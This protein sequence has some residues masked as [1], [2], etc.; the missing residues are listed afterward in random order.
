MQAKNVQVGSTY[1]AYNGDKLAR[2]SVSAVVT[3]RTGKN[4]SESGV[5]GRFIVGEPPYPIVV[6]KLSQLLGNY[7]EHVAL[8][9]ERERELAARHAA[10]FAKTERADELRGILYALIQ[11]PVPV[12]PDNRRQ[13]VFREY[14]MGLEMN[15]LAIE[16]LLPVLREVLTRGSNTNEGEDK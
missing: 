5:E 8:V 14:G 12:G 2:F 10:D 6:L 3:R 13:M 16:R 11:E 15:H 1:A 9:E 4:D 7:E